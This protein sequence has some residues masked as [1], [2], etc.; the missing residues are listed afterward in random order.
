MWAVARIGPTTGRIAHRTRETIP[1]TSRVASASLTALSILTALPRLAALLTALT[2]LSLLAL[3]PLLLTRLTTL[4]GL[5]VTRK[6]IGLAGPV[7][8]TLPTFGAWRPPGCCAPE[9]LPSPGR[10]HR[11][12]AID[13]PWRG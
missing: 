10:V 5:P 7:R 12:D 9:R 6:L 11:A 8:L 13:R 2:A 3:L 4:T 1:N